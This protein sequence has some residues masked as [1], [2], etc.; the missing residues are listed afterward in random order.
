MKRIYL[1]SNDINSTYF[2][3]D[4]TDFYEID[5]EANV[6]KAV[7]KLFP[8][9]FCNVFSG[10]FILDGDRRTPD[11]A[12][13]HKSFSHWFVVEVELAGHSFSGHVLP[14]VRCFRYGEPEASCINSLHRSFPFIS[15]SQL[16]TLLLYVP[17]HV[18]VIVN[19]SLKEW[20]EQLRGMDIQLLTVSVFKGRN[21]VSGYEIE[22]TLSVHTESIG[23]ALYNA[24]DKCLKISKSCGLKPGVIQIVDQFGVSSLW[25]V[26]E[27]SGILWIS[28]NSGI[29]LLEHKSYVQLVKTYDGRIMLKPS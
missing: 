10:S 4:P 27:S 9:Y 17:R 11:L 3:V 26:Q 12:L 2:Q 14:Q 20:H 29:S 25:N 23:F 15:P 18:L 28:K 1:E 7:N 19:L 6:V 21:D 13:I 5:F 24:M 8:E 16:Q 22:G